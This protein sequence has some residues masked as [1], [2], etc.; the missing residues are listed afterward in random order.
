MDYQNSIR[1]NPEEVDYSLSKQLFAEPPRSRTRALVQVTH[2]N[3]HVGIDADDLVMVDFSCQSIVCD[4]R[5]AITYDNEWVGVRRISLNASNQVL[6]E[7]DG[8]MRQLDT[9]QLN[10]IKVMGRILGVY[11][12]QH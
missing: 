8:E 9:N 6:L 3:P 12:S 4:G 5:Y 1:A 10:K 2:G 7:E 11:K